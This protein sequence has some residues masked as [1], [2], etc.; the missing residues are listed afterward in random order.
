MEGKAA[1]AVAACRFSEPAL[2][3]VDQI[4]QAVNFAKLS[5]LYIK[6]LY[7]TRTCPDQHRAAWLG[8]PYGRHQAQQ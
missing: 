5:V 7:S 6:Q 2:E 1:K 3:H 8:P 4:R